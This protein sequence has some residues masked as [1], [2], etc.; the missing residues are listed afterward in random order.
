MAWLPPPS[1]EKHCEG[2]VSCSRTKHIVPGKG[3]TWTAGSRV[4]HPNTEATAPLQS[5][6]RLEFIENGKM[7]K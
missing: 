2:K 3:S 4:D 6:R 1:G 7:Y 5:V